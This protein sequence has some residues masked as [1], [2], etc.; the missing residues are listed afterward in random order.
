[1]G[2][3]KGQSPENMEKIRAARSE[4]YGEKV[5]ATIYRRHGSDYYKRI[6]ALGGAVKGP[7]GFALMSPEKRSA[8]GSVGGRKSKRTKRKIVEI[9]K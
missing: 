4:N 3:H 6:G 7:K 5:R 9:T 1:M 2:N 8:A